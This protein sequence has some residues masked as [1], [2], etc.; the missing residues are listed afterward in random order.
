MHGTTGKCNC[1]YNDRNGGAAWRQTI[2]YPYM[3]ASV[4]GRGVA[5][6][7]V[8]NSPVYDTKEYSDVP[9]LD[10][11][12]VWNE[13]NEELTIFAVNRDMEDSLVL[14]CDSRNFPGYEVVEHIV[15]EH[16]DV[17]ARNTGTILTMWYHLIDRVQR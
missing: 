17:K 5:L 7:P 13:E 9:C 10:S 2:F 6:N 8:V 14:E 4:Y 16:E 1:T 12:A 15:M 3:H 11:T